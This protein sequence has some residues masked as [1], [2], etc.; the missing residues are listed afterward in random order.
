MSTR[1][2]CTPSIMYT[3]EIIGRILNFYGVNQL[4]EF[5]SIICWNKLIQST[6]CKDIESL[7]NETIMR[8]S[9]PNNIYIFPNW[10]HYFCSQH[11]RTLSD[12]FMWYIHVDRNALSNVMHM[13]IA[14]YSMFY[15]IFIRCQTKTSPN[16]IE[17][18]RLRSVD[19]MRIVNIVEHH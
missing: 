12:Q 19:A 8:H 2:W 7:L 5:A 4:I 3:C 6:K 17:S 9:Q 10:L 18:H 13:H 15:A 11:V 16:N 14:H 1:R